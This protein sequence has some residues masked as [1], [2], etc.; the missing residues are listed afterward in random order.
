[1]DTHRSVVTRAIAPALVALLLTSGSLGCSSTKTVAPSAGT[2]PA[3][4][5]PANA[6]H[7]IEW[8]WNRLDPSALDLVTEDFVFALAEG[9]SAG[10]PWHGSPWTRAVEVAALTR[11]FDTTAAVPRMRQLTLQL[12]RTM[13]AL[14]DPRP[15]KNNKW[16]RTIRS[17]VDLTAKLDISGG[18][19]V[20][21]VTGNA[22]F[23]LVRGDSAAIPPE[24]FA[25]GVRPDSTRWWVERWE[26]ETL[27]GGAALRP[28]P[29]RNL[30]L[31]MLKSL[32]LPALPAL[33]R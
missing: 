14:P 10:Q 15:G 17:H 26:D 28:E 12:D 23:F 4:D 33:R 18:L 5:S 1:M 8:T 27:S 29:A 6:V 9:D 20:W 22:L 32:F 19:D 3:P 13:I 11:M 16:H 31:G 30:T 24:L 25:R 21:I 2:G 7:R